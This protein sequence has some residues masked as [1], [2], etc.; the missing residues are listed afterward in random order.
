LVI[1]LADVWFKSWL[2]YW[3]YW[4]R[5]LMT[6]QDCTVLWLGCRMASFQ[7][8]S[9]FFIIFILPLTLCSLSNYHQLQG[10][11]HCAHISYLLVSIKAESV[12]SRWINAFCWSVCRLSVQLACC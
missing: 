10:S 5:S 9:I 2:G 8:L 6:R 12:S 1:Y 7:I 11:K 3:L 4:L